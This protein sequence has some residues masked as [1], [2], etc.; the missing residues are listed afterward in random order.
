M[1]NNL[2]LDHIGIAVE[3]IKIALK[4]CEGIF[5][6][7]LQEGDIYIDKTQKVKVAFVKIGETKFEL[8]EPISDD[9]PVKNYI[10]KGIN[11]YHVCFRVADIENAI[12]E[13]RRLGGIVTVPPVPATA[14]NEKKIAFVYF[15]N[16]GLVEWVEE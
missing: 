14:F 13:S 2:I 4:L 7:D 8:V 3:N 5:N 1:M 9:S 11:L 10:R 6:L 12:K 15:K 16:L